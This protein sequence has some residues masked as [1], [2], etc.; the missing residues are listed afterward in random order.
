VNP[1]VAVGL[2]YFVGGEAVG[3]RTLMGTLLVLVSV[4][5]ITTTPKA[6][7]V[8]RNKGEDVAE[9]RPAEVD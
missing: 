9:L 5:T 8:E 2:G 6:R 4:V 7:Q 1:V 3:L